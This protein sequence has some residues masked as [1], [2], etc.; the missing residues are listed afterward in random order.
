MI[1]VSL[2]Y[3]DIYTSVASR[4]RR[5]EEY[6]GRVDKVTVAGWT[7]HLIECLMCVLLFC[8]VKTFIVGYTYL[9]L[10]CEGGGGEY[11]YGAWY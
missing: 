1:S 2:S 4:C 7:N 10:G 6:A 5:L 11:V 8:G 3:A 9:I